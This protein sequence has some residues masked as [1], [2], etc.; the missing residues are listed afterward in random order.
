MQ[1][2]VSETKQGHSESD[3]NSFEDKVYVRIASQ[4]AG[5]LIWCLQMR[6]AFWRG[7]MIL[8][9]SDSD[10][11]QCQEWTV[12]SSGTSRNAEGFTKVPKNVKVLESVINMLV[13]KIGHRVILLAL[14]DDVQNPSKHASAE[15]HSKAREMAQSL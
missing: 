1:G 14:A 8:K 9:Q 15:W 7:A 4:W 2:D 3:D 10:A 12:A 13:D 11:G 5:E 6:S